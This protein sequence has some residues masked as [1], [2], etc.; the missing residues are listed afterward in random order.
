MK[1]SIQLLSAAAA[2]MTVAAGVAVAQQLTVEINKVIDAG[3]GEKIGT[4]A[5][6]GDRNGTAFKVAVNVSPLASTVST[7]TRRGTAPPP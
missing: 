6:T 7:C 5:I 1:T 2:I 3:V 4:V